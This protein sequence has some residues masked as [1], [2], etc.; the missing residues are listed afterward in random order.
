MPRP[1]PVSFR[2]DVVRVARNRDDGVTVEQIGTVFG[3]HPMTLHKWMRQADIDEGAKPGKS[4]VEST[5][6]DELRRRNRL[7]E[8]EKEVLRRAAAYLSQANLPGKALPAREG[9]R[10]RRDPR[11]GD[12][13]GTQARPPALLPLAG[14]ADH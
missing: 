4:T 5:E 12:V 3:V 9:A 2:D 14:Q 11:R 1:Y 8:Q 6:L 13:A 10:R 7:L